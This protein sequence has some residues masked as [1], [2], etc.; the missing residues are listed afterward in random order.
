MMGGPDLLLSVGME[1][2][3]H[4]L[5][6]PERRKHLCQLAIEGIQVNL[7]AETVLQ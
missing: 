1:L 5:H 4:S 7:P 3:Y 2:L 6:R